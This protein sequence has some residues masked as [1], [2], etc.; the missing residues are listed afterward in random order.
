MPGLA[1]QSISSS[2]VVTVRDGQ[3]C[4]WIDKREYDKLVDQN[5]SLRKRVAELEA[6]A[7][8]FEARLA[9]LEFK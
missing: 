5:A 1:Q 9:R 3:Q 4:T 8:T 7:R 6:G 2:I